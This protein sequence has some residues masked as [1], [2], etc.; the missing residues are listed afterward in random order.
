[1]G[2]T[3]GPLRRRINVV[4]TGRRARRRVLD[5]FWAV[6]QAAVAAT[7][8]WLIA[9][10]VLGHP[11]P[12]FAPIAAAISLSTSHIQRSRRIAQMVAGVLLGI[13]VAEV[14]TP[15]LG[16]STPALGAIVLATMIVALAAGVGF[17]NDG[18]MF[19]NQAA[20]SAVLVVTVHRHGTGAER[21]IDVLV[22]GAVA[23]VLG[24][25]LFPAQPLQLLA[26]AE[27]D[28]LRTLAARLGEVVVQLRAGR[29]LSDTWSL[30]TGHLIHRQL[31]ALTRARATARVNVR[32]APRRF[33][34]RAVVDAEVQRTARLDMLANAVLSLIRGATLRSDGRHAPPP[35][36]QEEIAAMAAGLA[37]LADADRPWPEELLTGLE[38]RS[39]ETVRAVSARDIDSD[40]VVASILRATA[41]DFIAVIQER[42]LTK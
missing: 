34:Q 26:D 33:R 20:A 1:M 28:V 29:D 4:R 7:L 18:L 23:L 30:Q 25:G 41:R 15:L 10:R 27:S 14:L 37:D 8:A 22:G 2:A 40:Q 39:D 42:P 31:S 21:A 5:S 16:V 19:P 36:L 6:L 12:F 38:R 32:V 24:V 13:G 3:S 35:E 9:H 11:Q 17:F